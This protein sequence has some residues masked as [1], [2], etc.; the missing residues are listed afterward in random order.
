M[1]PLTA[2]PRDSLTAAQVST[3]LT[4]PALQVDYGCDLLDANLALVA[5]ISA[6]VSGGI[7]HRDN[8]AVVHGNVDLTISRTLAWGRDRI[9]PFMVLS[10]GEVTARFNLG[11]Y[12]LTTPALPLAESPATFA[13]TGYDQLH[14]LQDNI[15]D[16][17]SV[18]ANTNVLT[19]VKAA[20]T[21]AG[22]TAPVLLDSTSAAAVLLSPLTFP[23]TSSKNPVWLEVVNGLLATISYQG[24]WCDWDG[25][26]RSGPYLTPDTRP[27]EWVFNVGDLSVGVVAVARSVT[28]DVW[29]VPNWWRFVRN[30]LTAAP[31]EGSGQYTVQNT[32]TGPSSQ[33]SVGRVV[34]AP[35][36]YL[37]AVDQ[38]SLQAQ[39]DALVATAMRSSEVI[40]AK[41]SPFPLA[42]HF[43]VSTY[44][45]A[46]LGADRK[47]QCRSWSLPLDG[48][49]TDY[50]LESV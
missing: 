5:D 1:Q 32:S 41:L 43:D 9:R 46:Q 48:S 18:A 3:L 23:L 27:P 31:A 10:A 45:D 37:D 47:A 33:V 35:V 14:L 40:T 12:L 2:A 25:A 13:V 42:W 36:T 7:V 38:A 20:L 17:Y 22:I 11:V 16:S 49:D 24:I 44:S 26:F 4:A 19:A 50:I 15:G 28:N 39:G 21:A 6:D 29:G 8:Y 34:H 30:G